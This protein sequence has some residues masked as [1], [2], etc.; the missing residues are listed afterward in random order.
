MGLLTKDSVLGFQ[1]LDSF[2]ESL[3]SRMDIPNFTM[4]D[5]VY[6]LKGLV[7]DFQISD[8]PAPLPEICWYRASA[9]LLNLVSVVWV[10]R[11]P[12]STLLTMCSWGR[13]RTAGR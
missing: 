9:A 6:A 8:F 12:V 5:F 2:L 3:E 13:L 7:L 10:Y 11:K 1:I 4:Q